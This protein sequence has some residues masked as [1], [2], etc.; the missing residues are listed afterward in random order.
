MIPQ[1]KEMTMCWS[2]FSCLI[3][4]EVE[5]AS[6]GLVGF[7]SVHGRLDLDDVALDPSNQGKG[8]VLVLF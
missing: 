8:N 6:Q 2:P 5:L 7:D 3:V 4:G 1:N